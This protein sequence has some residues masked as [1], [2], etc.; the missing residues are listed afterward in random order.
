MDRV[1]AQDTP[2]FREDLT[3]VA[4]APNEDYVAF[5]GVWVVPENGIAYVEPVA[6]D[7]L[8]RRLGLGRA[9]VVEALRRARD[10]GA[11]T[12]WV[13]SDQEFY[14]SFGFRVTCT[15]N[16]YLRQLS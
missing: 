8:Y 1:R 3:I 5:A 13:G 2:G 7:P 14:R 11:R 4:V 12:A 15:T 16:M 6:T 10:A 9:A